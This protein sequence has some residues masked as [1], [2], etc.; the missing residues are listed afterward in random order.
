MSDI[1]LTK[2][3]LAQYSKRLVKTAAGMAIEFGLKPEQVLNLNSVD[4]PLR[5]DYIEGWRQDFYRTTTGRGYSLIDTVVMRVLD[6]Y[7]NREPELLGDIDPTALGNEYAKLQ[8]FIEA[9]RAR[10]YESFR[11]D[12]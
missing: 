5:T 12:I 11:F 4:D 9:E 8:D 2:E 7:K 1:L 3:Q 6:E 10:S